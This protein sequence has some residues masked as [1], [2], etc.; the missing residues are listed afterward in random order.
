MHG[1]LLTGVHQLTRKAA[2]RVFFRCFYV[3]RRHFSFYIAFDDLEYSQRGL[4]SVRFELTG[5]R[6]LNKARTQVLPCTVRVYRNRR[7][8]GQKID[9]PNDLLHLT[10]AV[11]PRFVE[12]ED[13]GFVRLDCGGP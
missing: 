13:A 6:G 9:F 4:R 2:S 7:V 8:F 1:A 11:S 3:L 10:S 12:P 5:S